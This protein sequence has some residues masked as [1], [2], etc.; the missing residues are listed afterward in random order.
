MVFL[1]RTCKIS[2]P[3][4]R[5][6]DQK[7]DK[8]VYAFFG[9]RYIYRMN[10]YNLASL[11]AE[12]LAPYASSASG[13][14]LAFFFFSLLLAILKT[15]P[16]AKPVASLC[17][18]WNYV[19]RRSNV[20]KMETRLKQGSRDARDL[21]VQRWRRLTAGRGSWT[22]FAIL[23]ICQACGSGLFVLACGV[24]RRGGGYALGNSDPLT[25]RDK[26]ERKVCFFGSSAN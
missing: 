21:V 23:I 9:K 7:G 18:G 13:I 10:S 11:L 12:F 20:R 2:P 1:H 8:Y 4:S 25:F 5:K 16:V 14:F 15:H 26:A 19:Q 3:R 6:A 24:C 22:S 17:T